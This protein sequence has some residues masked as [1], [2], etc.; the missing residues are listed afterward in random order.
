MQFGTQSR[1]LDVF[2]LRQNVI[3]AVSANSK[4][5]PKAPSLADRLVSHFPS[6]V[7]GAHNQRAYKLDRHGEI[8]RPV[9]ESSKRRL[10]NSLVHCNPERTWVAP[11][12]DIRNASGSVALS[13]RPVGLPTNEH[14][15][16]ILSVRSIRP[17]SQFQLGAS[18]PES[19][20]EQAH[21]MK[22]ERTTFFRYF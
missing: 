20:R 7:K 2:G 8:L 21:E 5:W 4:S 13:Q 10:P 11:K 18:L 3:K 6:L 12:S 1:K 22:T 16:A 15:L 19:G 17:G 14:R 9:S